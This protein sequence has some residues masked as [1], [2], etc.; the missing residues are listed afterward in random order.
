MIGQITRFTNSLCYCFDQNL[1]IRAKTSVSQALTHNEAS[2]ADKLRNINNL[3]PKH[4]KEYKSVFEKSASKQFPEPRPWDHSI[5]LKPNF[6]AQDCKI[7]L[8]TPIEQKKMD[9][10][11][12]QNL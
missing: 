2:G 6:V 11:L 9:K 3:L 12:D 5:D 10:F 7:Y 4:Y 1:W 8:L